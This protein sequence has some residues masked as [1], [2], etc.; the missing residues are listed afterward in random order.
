VG[1]LDV[2]AADREAVLKA[3]AA[4][5]LKRSASQV[6]VCGVRINLA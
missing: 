6:L 2:K 3:A 1:G 4:R 5:G